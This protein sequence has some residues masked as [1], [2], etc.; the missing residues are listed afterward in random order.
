MRS[1]AKLTNQRTLLR[2]KVLEGRNIFNGYKR[3]IFHNKRSNS[4]EIHYLNSYA[5]DIINQNI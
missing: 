3:D 5:P 2:E 1:S 4:P